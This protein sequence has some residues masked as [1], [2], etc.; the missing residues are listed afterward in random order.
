[1]AMWG[2]RGVTSASLRARAVIQGICAG[3]K[4][5]GKS[6]LGRDEPSR[7]YEAADA[8]PP[9]PESAVAAAAPPDDAA[10][11]TA[12]AQAEAALEVD[13]LMHVPFVSVFGAYVHAGGASVASPRDGTVDLCYRC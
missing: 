11:E 12:R 6:L 7:W 2:M 1:M 8:L 10:V 9:L 13:T 4:E 3:A 5:G